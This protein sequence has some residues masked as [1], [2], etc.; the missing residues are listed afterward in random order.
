MHDLLSVLLSMPGS[1]VSCM[2]KASRSPSQLLNM[3]C[4][5][6]HQASVGLSGTQ[7][8]KV[9]LREIVLCVL[10]NRTLLRCLVQAVQRQC[11]C[12][13]AAE[14]MQLLPPPGATTCLKRL[15]TAAEL[16]CKSSIYCH[17]HI[18]AACC[19]S[20][21]DAAITAASRHQA[22]Q[23]KCLQAVTSEPQTVT[24]FET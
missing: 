15:E 24:Q 14:P 21:N 4:S 18:M 13:I 5:I 22:R 7:P 17:R 3:L 23:L 10:A 2:N 11:L 9:A 20:D 16:C 1:I 6:S 19:T 8:A 12:C